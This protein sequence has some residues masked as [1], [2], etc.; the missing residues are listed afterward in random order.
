VYVDA[1]RLSTADSVVFEDDTP[2]DHA[3]WQVDG[4]VRSSD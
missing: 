3:L 2:A 4:F 1:V